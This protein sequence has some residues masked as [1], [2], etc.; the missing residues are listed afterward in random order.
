MNKLYCATLAMLILVAACKKDDDDTANPG[1]GGNNGG[2]N[3]GADLITSW[4]PLV[5]YR[6]QVVTFN[7][8]PFNTDMAQNSI[9]A[10]GEPFEVISV[11][12]TQ[13]TARPGPDMQT[14]VPGYNSVIITSGNAVDTI[15]YVYWKRPF[16][17]MFLEDNLDD[18]YSGAPSRPG[19]RSV[20]RCISATTTGMS[21]SVNGQAI[22]DAITVDSGYY[23]TLTF[24]I[25][26]SMGTG[27]DENQQT[28]TLLSAT[29]G[30]GR[31][32]TLTIGWAPTP[33]ME[34]YGLELVGG[35]SSFDLSDMISNGQVLNF[36]VYGNYL[37]AG[38]PWT[39]TGPSGTVGVW[40][41]G[42]YGSESFIVINPVSL[43]DG[44]YVLSL[45]GTFYSY[46]FTLVN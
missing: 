4:S 41:T 19:D 12:S 16:D 45:D 42:N 2:G 27:D 43:Q 36:R 17:L 23:C 9:T 3:V 39:L 18:I 24:R 28:T 34:V 29:N 44:Y 22:T 7:G 8:G 35:G 26:V 14:A 38:Q 33:D 6:D 31:T 15:P 13:I 30:D 11:T 10:W 32:D 40:G 21:I 46:G 37:H 5:P 20:F 25:P 1:G